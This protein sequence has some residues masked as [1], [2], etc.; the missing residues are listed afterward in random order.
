MTDMDVDLRPDRRTSTRKPASPPAVGASTPTASAR[1]FRSASQAEAARTSN[2]CQICRDKKVKCSG[3]RP[4]KYCSKRGLDCVFSASEK[5]KLYSIS[6]A[7]LRTKLP[8]MSDEVERSRLPRSLLQRSC[9]MSKI[10][11][12]RSQSCILT[13]SQMV[14]AQFHHPLYWFSLGRRCLNQQ[15][16]P[17]SKER[18]PRRSRQEEQLHPSPPSPR[19]RPSDPRLRRSSSPAP[20]PAQPPA[21]RP[22]STP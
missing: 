15:Y 22:P 1:R 7:S 5:R 13:T 20:T 10:L 3:Q 19:A 4:C 18:E 12:M 8:I 2:A 21:R 14:T 9:T 16:P 6:Y 11:R 17:P